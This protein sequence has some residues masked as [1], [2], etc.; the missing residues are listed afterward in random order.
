[1]GAKVKL[2]EVL[3]DKTGEPATVAVEVHF[4]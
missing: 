1:V 4:Q 2:L 3:R